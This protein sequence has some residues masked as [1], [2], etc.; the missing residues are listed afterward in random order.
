MRQTKLLA[1]LALVSALLAACATPPETKTQP[2]QPAAKVE[3]A[4]PATQPAAPTEAPKAQ[5]ATAAP[6][7]A[8]PVAEAPGAAKTLAKP[9]FIDFYAPW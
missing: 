1:V 4:A 5:P 9:V 8:A 3:V 7:V 2:A 6:A